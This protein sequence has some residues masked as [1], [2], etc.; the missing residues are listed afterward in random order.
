M[1]DLERRILVVEDEGIVA[2]DIRTTLEGLGYSVPVTAASAEEALRAATDSS[3]SLALLDIRIQGK[4][5]GIEAADQL[6]ERFGIPIVFLTSY[7]DEATLSRAKKVQPHGY[8]LKPFNERELHAAIEMALYKH[9]MEN[10]VARSERLAALG[11]MA[12]GMAHE[13]NNPLAY[14][15]ANVQFVRECLGELKRCFSG[16]PQPDVMEAARASLHEAGTALSDAADGAERVRRVVSGLKA[17]ARVDGRSGNDCTQVEIALAAALKLTAHALRHHA[18]IEKE[19]GPTPAIKLNE[20][21][22]VQV[23]TNLLMNAA[24]AMD[25]GDAEANVIRIVTRT[26]NLGRAVVEIRD[27]GHGMRR[28]QLSRV[29]EPF[30]TTKDAGVGTGL[31]LPIC[32]V[33]LLDLGGEILL[34]SVAGEGTVVRVF[35]PPAPSGEPPSQ[36]ARAV[37]EQEGRKGRVLVIDDE[38]A[39]GTALARMLSGVHEVV[40]ETDA[41]EALT[42]LARDA[43]FDVIL[44]DV[45]M[46]NMS[47]ED[48]C[49]ALRTTAP[50]LADRVVL[51][52]GGAF[53]PRAQQFIATSKNPSINKPFARETLLAAIAPF[54]R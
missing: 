51:M 11:R 44:C 6:R 36:R 37:S 13:I 40:A 20:G 17:F 5:D 49:R 29:F 39:L 9:E 30:F 38:S 43:R 33:I 48:F 7:S 16:R 18:R 35:L 53:S 27:T 32:Q 14:V 2:E 41:R 45:M 50:A 23:F 46:P 52:T 26:D 21:Q 47:G 19:Y 8:L 1:Q 25:D 28:E 42:R 24:Q 34:D 12:V 22:L 3:P 4:M 10:R 54:V 15:T 31:G